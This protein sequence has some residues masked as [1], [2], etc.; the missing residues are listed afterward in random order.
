MIDNINKL[1]E[2]SNEKED[3]LSKYYDLTNTQ[4][5]LIQS[6]ELEEFDKVLENKTKLIKKTDNLDLEFIKLYDEF[7]AKE[8]IDSIEEIEIDKYNNLKELK[9]IISKI[10]KLLKDIEKVEKANMTLMERSFSKVKLGLRNIKHT[11]AAHR[12]YSHNPVGSIM[13]D[14]KK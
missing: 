2:I 8:N 5:N 10:S 14:E 9:D 6:E 1:I 4:N 7:K 12:G 13:I 11:K 3:L